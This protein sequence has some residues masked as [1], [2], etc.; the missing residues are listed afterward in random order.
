MIPAHLRQA[1]PI[2]TCPHEDCDGTDFTQTTT[3]DGNWADVDGE[4][5]WQCTTCKRKW[6]R[7]VI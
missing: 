6:P 4:T 5:W 3:P 7:S 1:P 2:G